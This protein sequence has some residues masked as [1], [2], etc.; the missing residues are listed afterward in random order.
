MRTKN[1]KC[2]P[3]RVWEYFKKIKSNFVS[4]AALT[5]LAIL[6]NGQEK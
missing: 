6:Q 4:V 3:K 5:V 1:R 2:H